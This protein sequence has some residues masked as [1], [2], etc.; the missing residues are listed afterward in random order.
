M[1]EKILEKLEISEKKRKQ[2]K[3]IAIRER[4]IKVYLTLI[5]FLLTIIA[6]INSV[7]L[8]AAKKQIESYQ[9]HSADLQSTIDDQHELYKSTSAVIMQ[10]SNNIVNLHDDN[11]ELKKKYNSALDVINYYSNRAEL[12]NKY[13]FALFYN[14]ERTDIEYETLE[15]L[16]QFVVD[17]KYGTDILVLSLALV[18]TES[19]GI[20]DAKNPT[21]SASGLGQLLYSTARVC[22]EDFLGYGKGTY[23]KE[24]AYDPETNLKMTLALVNELSKQSKGNPIKVIDGYRGLHSEGYIHEVKKYVDAAGYELSALQLY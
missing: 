17:N 23:K 12:Y 18:M 5:C 6:A 9:Q 20:A 8:Y 1:E 2:L 21:S 11:E 3:K 24:Y 19:H 15:T 7:Q 4:K 16:E 22:Y 13:E 14:G 10:L